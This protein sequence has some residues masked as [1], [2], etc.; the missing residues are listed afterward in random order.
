MLCQCVEI[1]AVNKYDVCVWLLCFGCGCVYS[2]LF[3]KVSHAY[4]YIYIERERDIYRYTHICIYR[5]IYIYIYIY[6]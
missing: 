2:T 4:I 5:Y 6:I 3:S 1:C